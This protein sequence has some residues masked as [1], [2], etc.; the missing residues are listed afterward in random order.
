VANPTSLAAP[1]P[2]GG[3]VLGLIK[4]AALVIGPR[5][6]VVRAEEFGDQAVET[7]W[8]GEHAVFTCV[9]RDFDV[10]GIRE[11]FPV[12]ASGTPLGS[13]ITRSAGQGGST[14]AARRILFVPYS[15]AVHPFV[16]LPAAKPVWG[17]AAE[18]RLSAAE[19]VGLLCSFYATP[20]ADGRVYQIARKNQLAL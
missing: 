15:E 7:I 10:D 12:V 14:P 17:S 11:M 1:F 16:Y 4:S 19:E 9:L 8:N 18:I 5:V 6:Y 20:A 13:S 2:Y 3:S